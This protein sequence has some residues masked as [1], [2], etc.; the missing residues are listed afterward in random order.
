MRSIIINTKVEMKENQ[1][2]CEDPGSFDGGVGGG[3][4][5]QMT[6]KGSEFF[7]FFFFLLFFIY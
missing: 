4:Q 5:I 3:G 6:E 2:S 7:F 1:I